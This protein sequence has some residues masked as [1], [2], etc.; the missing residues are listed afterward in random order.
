MRS[1]QTRD[2]KG[3]SLQLNLLSSIS[4][5]VELLKSNIMAC[6]KNSGDKTIICREGKRGKA[7]PRGEK[8]ERGS[9]GQ[10]GSKGQS[11]ISGTKGEKGNRGAKGE[12]GLSMKKPEMIAKLSSTE[13]REGSSATFTCTAKGNPKPTIEWTVSGTRV[14]KRTERFK[15]IGENALEISSLQASDSGEV[16]CVAKN[17]IGSAESIAMLGVICEFN[18]VFPLDFFVCEF[19]FKFGNLPSDVI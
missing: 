6:H 3:G 15:L 19:K 18:F 9:Q 14:S 11:G 8:G 7:G 2:V 5:S 1:R 4:K 17:F 10:H 16:K 13:T 12:P